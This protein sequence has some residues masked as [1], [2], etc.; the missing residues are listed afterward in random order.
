MHP[1][2]ARKPITV[3]SFIRMNELIRVSK[4]ESGQQVVSARELYSYLGYESNK[5][6]RWAKSK[7]L[8]NDFAIE[9]QDWMGLDIN[10]QG[11]E[12]KDY[13]LSLDFA[14]RLSM[15]ARTEKGENV[16][17][18]FIECEKMTQKLI[19]QTYKEAL[20]ALVAA[21]EEKEQLLLQVDNLSTALDTLVEWVSIIKVAQFNKVSEKNFDWRRLKNKSKEMGFALKKAESPRYGYQNL[22]HVATFKVVYPQYNYNF[23]K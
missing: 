10:V 9:S 16:R 7:I 19:P 13:V 21:E 2:Q 17:N 11:N 8:E 22:Y 1:F 14:K 12:T 15:M 5:F 4:N 18:Y 6:A 20:L 3:F 23:L